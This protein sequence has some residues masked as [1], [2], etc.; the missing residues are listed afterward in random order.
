MTRREQREQQFFTAFAKHGPLNI[1]LAS[2]QSCQPPMPDIRCEI[3]G[4]NYFFELA[5]VVP[6]EQAQALATIGMYTIMIPDKSE[7]G[8]RAMAN[9]LRQ[10]KLK[11]YD[12][13]GAPVDLLLYF[14]KDI[15]IYLSDIDNAEADKTDIDLALQECKQRGRFQRIWTYDS[16]TD[17]VKQL[18]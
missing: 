3:D 15:S 5:E 16:W 8:P 2:L 7:R 1:N 4:N 6:E 10:K 18:A 11:D 9:I 13:G 14:N 12:T 17:Q